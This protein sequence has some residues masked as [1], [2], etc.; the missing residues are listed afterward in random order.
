MKNIS[1]KANNEIVV[2][3]TT[4]LS[5]EDLCNVTTLAQMRY[6]I[7]RVKDLLEQRE[8]FIRTNIKNLILN[9]FPLSDKYA[10]MLLKMIIKKFYPLN[11]EQERALF[12]NIRKDSCLCNYKLFV[13]YGRHLINSERSEIY[14]HF[15]SFDELGIRSTTYAYGE[16]SYKS[17]VPQLYYDKADGT[18]T[19]QIKNLEYNP[20]VYKENYILD[21][22]NNTEITSS[23]SPDYIKLLAT[24]SSLYRCAETC[25]WGSYWGTDDRNV[26]LKRHQRHNAKLRSSLM[27]NEFTSWDW[28]LV[29]DIAKGLNIQD[30]GL[31][32]LLENK[33]FIAQMGIDN[34][35]E[36]FDHLQEISNHTLHSIDVARIELAKKK[37]QDEN[38]KRGLYAYLPLDY[39][40]IAEH[41][42]ELD[43]NVI[44]KNPRVI[45]SQPLFRLYLRMIETG[46]CEIQ[47]SAPMYD[48]IEQLLDD[49][50]VDELIRTYELD[51]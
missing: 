12:S 40:F 47:C 14:P 5:Y 25:S 38:L 37:Y 2:S 46:K 44:A 16:P 3:D 29:E 48:A 6:N 1:I 19:V 34:I 42:D 21:F 18:Q 23:M 30:I 22:H 8:R 39:T 33:G 35:N 31:K 45:W 7:N 11:E 13:K 36:T 15:I 10:K 28:D 26:F 4:S 9:T 43:W 50:M 17:S 51:K 41:I 20:N 24:N 32:L 49:E 27:S